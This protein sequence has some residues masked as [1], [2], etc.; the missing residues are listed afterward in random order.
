MAMLKNI[1]II[2][3]L[4]PLARTINTTFLPCDS[5]I[6]GTAVDCCDRPIKS[7]HF[8]KSPNVVSLNLSRTKIRKVGQNDFLNLPN[9]D[10]LKIMGNCRPDQLRPSVKQLCKMEIN[11]DALKK[12][13][14]LKYLYLSGNS[15]TSIPRLPQNLL[16]LDLQNNCIFNIAEPLNTPQLQGL[17]LGKNCY[18]A[19]PCGQPYFIN[20]S[21][22]RQLSELQNLTLGYNNFTAIPLE[23]PP[24]LELLDL[25]ENAITEVL[26]GAFANL[27]NLKS[28]T[29]EWNCQRCDHAARPCFPCP[30]NL[31][32]LLNNNSLYAENSS[33]NFLSLRGNSL[34]TF[35]VGLFQSLKKLES[36]DL[37]DNLLAYA[38]RNGT[39]FK[40]LK[41]LTW[42]SLIYN[43]EP[44]M[45]FPEL[46]LSPYI[47]NMS[48]L[49]YLL[50]S[51][52]FFHTFSNESVSVVSKLQNL[53]VLEM[54]MNFI[55]TSLPITSLKQLPSLIKIDLSQ[56]LINFLPCC[57][58]SSSRIVAQ[59]LYTRNFPD[60]GLMLSDHKSTSGSNTWESSQT[61]RGELLEHNVRQIKF[62]SDFKDTL[63]HGKLWFDLS[64]N[65]ILSI[66]KTVFVGM[67]NAVCLDLSFNYMS[68]AL[69]GGL[70]DS[71]NKLVFLNLSF[72]RLDLYYNDS[73]SELNNT[74]KVLDV[75]NN[76]FH[77]QMKGMGHH[78]GFLQGLTKLEALSLAN[79]GIGMRI[80]PRL[81]SS[82]LNYLYFY[83][84]HLD[85]MWDYDNNKY[86]SF[87]Q[88]LTNLT[89][90]D[91]SNNELKSISALVVCNLPQSLEE[92]SI[93]KNKLNNFPWENIKTLSNLSHLNLS[94]N[95]LDSLPNKVIDFGAHFTLLDLSHNH[96]S[97]I[98]DDFF[99]I[100]ESLNYLYLSHNQIKALNHQFLPPAFKNGSAL[101]ILTLHA[102]PFKCD[103]DTS[104][105]TDFLRTTA[106]Q[107]PYL[108]TYIHCDYPESQQGASVL[109]TDQRSCQDIYG[110]LAFLVC[111]FLAVTFTVLPLLKHL[112]G[113]DL[114]YCLQVLWAGHKGYSQ[115]AGSN[116]RYQYDAFVVFDTRNKAVCD[117]VYN[118]LTVNLEISGHR[119]FCLCL[120]E[121]DW[122]P[123]LSCI[124]NLH[125]AVNSSVKTVFVLSSGATGG[126]TV[127]GVI[128]QAFFMVQQ[129]L[130]DE[131]V[132]AAILVLL[133]EM[134]PKL[135]YLQLRKRLCKDS[136]LS[137]PR[138]PRAQPLFWNRMR[139]ALSSDNLK[140]YDN[141]MSE[142]FI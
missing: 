136:V 63:C 142:S 133:D 46:I 81:I 116:S 31:P 130:L 108:T 110:G 102:N 134:F 85:I 90:L 35:P 64:Q 80:D 77:F 40:E 114:W 16:V 72:N 96:L 22:F 29:L 117:W 12:L 65:N 107:I 48:A 13:S 32:L 121:R 82:S 20:E 119:N 19:N 18:Y 57:S 54:R 78:F 103:C 2:F 84:N 17:Y 41:G 71:M 75:S 124:D 127:N 38:I 125:N 141:N 66:Y 56:N 11:N 51:G 39:F 43:Y 138:N 44:L 112:Y 132:D 58:C 94:H 52:N 92:L 104:S 74:L 83:G 9:L 59:N 123:G 118:E 34:K 6:N 98:P 69:K 95:F 10:T 50:L 23:L 36:L 49:Q 76:E 73:F 126:E 106:V 55:N 129:R 33:I 47:C 21:V 120:E 131:K 53:K 122:I 139:M 115:L 67:E 89:Y 37:S 60:Q 91:I 140:F 1:F 93:S 14:K 101:Q 100:A 97:V 25:K 99:S 4:L 111:S 87:F 109:S 30:H 137:W 45:I 68:Q 42:I 135:R 26:E 24:S 15:L 105:F 8:I 86:T 5:D 7:F 27:T 3:Q 88:N 62:L 128:R 113:W 70:F 79:N 28:L 61:N